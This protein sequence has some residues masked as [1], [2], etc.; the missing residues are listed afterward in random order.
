MAV[1]FIGFFLSYEKSCA[2]VSKKR[3]TWIIEWIDKAEGS[4]WFA[5]GRRFSEFLGR[6]NFVVGSLV[7]T[8]RSVAQRDS[9]QDAGHGPPLPA[10]HQRRA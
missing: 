3:L 5:T 2:G 10:L 4:G 1:E 9:G 7:L 6:L 8:Q